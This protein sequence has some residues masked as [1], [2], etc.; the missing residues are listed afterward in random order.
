MD[1]VCNFN[2]LNIVIPHG[3]R[4][5]NFKISSNFHKSKVDLI[6]V[7]HTSPYKNY[8]YVLEN[9]IQLALENKKSNF[10]FLS[11]GEITDGFSVD[12]WI[13]L[14]PENLEVKFEGNLSHEKTLNM[15]KKSD[16][17]IF[18]SSAENFPNVLLEYMSL[19]SV[20]LSNNIEPMKSIL[21]E[22]WS[23]F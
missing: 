3:V 1:K 23:I 2:N 5:R 21:N 8:D 6:Y 7:S 9:L 16:I 11:I 13:K 15:I 4:Q 12:K 20:C 18:A 14:L 19:G 17:C 22:V 10:R